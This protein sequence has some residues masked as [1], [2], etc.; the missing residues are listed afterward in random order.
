[1]DPPWPPFWDVA[2]ARLVGIVIAL[3]LIQ[4]GQT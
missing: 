2:V 1:M 3:I 4:I